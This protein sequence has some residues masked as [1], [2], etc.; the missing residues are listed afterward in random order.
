MEINKGGKM[1]KEGTKDTNQGKQKSLGWFSEIF[2]IVSK[3][4]R[5]E[6]Q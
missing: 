6:S 5:D 3:K 2:R 4:S 1:M